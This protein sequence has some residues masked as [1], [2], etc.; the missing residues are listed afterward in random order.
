MS[1]QREMPKYQSHKQ[2]WALKIK[3]IVRDSDLAKLQKRET[4]GKATIKAVKVGY[5]PFDVD[6]AYVKKHNPQEGGYFVIYK[7]GYESYSPAE[8]FEGGYILI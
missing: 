6:A 7:D 8:A 1:N 4:T 3:H 2:V 5:A